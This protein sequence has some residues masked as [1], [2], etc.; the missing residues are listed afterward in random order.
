MKTKVLAASFTSTDDV[1]KL[2]G[3]H[4][5]TLP[6]H[7]LEQLDSLPA[8]TPKPKSLFE[9]DF[10]EIPVVSVMYLYHKEAFLKATE[11]GYHGLSQVSFTCCVYLFDV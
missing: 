10:H 5:V 6:P 3:I 1:M 7:L 4:H 9:E 11:R 2:A 8:S